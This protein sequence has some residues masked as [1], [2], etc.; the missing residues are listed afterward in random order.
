MLF[1]F[2][3]RIRKDEVCTRQKHLRE[4]QKTIGKKNLQNE[5]TMRYQYIDET[6]REE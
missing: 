1:E 4:I 2:Q 5:E 6:T 3:E